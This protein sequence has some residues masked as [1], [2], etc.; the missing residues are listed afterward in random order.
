MYWPDKPSD[1]SQ[2]KRN[3]DTDNET[4]GAMLNRNN[5]A[6]GA[7]ERIN[8][9]RRVQHKPELTI[10]EVQENKSDGDAFVSHYWNSSMAH[11]QFWEGDQ[12]ARKP[13]FIEGGQNNDF[14]FTES[15]FHKRHCLSNL[16]MILAWYVTKNA[17]EK[18]T[19]DMNVHAMHCLVSVLWCLRRTMLDHIADDE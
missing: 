16:R 8:V 4:Y 3:A 15:T 5:L 9:A 6:L 10:T 12:E 1:S 13:D 2:V 19:R 14:G 7:I 18:M 17:A 11:G